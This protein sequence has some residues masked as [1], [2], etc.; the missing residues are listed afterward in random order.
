MINSKD[1]GISSTD[2]D[3]NSFR[4]HLLLPSAGSW[5]E[6]RNKMN[7]RIMEIKGSDSHDYKNKYEAIVEV[8]IGKKSIHQAFKDANLIEIDY[9]GEKIKALWKFGAI[10]DDQMET[11]CWLIDH[12][13]VYPPFIEVNKADSKEII[14]QAIKEMEIQKKEG[15]FKATPWQDIGW[16]EFQGSD[17]DMTGQRSMFEFGNE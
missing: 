7:A 13:G 1:N 4:E 8:V 16:R 9:K 3:Y 2:E 12:I 11:I 5:T 14:S 17:I 6:A 15:T 10:A